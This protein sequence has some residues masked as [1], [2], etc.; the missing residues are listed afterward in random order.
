MLYNCRVC[1]SASND[2][3]AQYTVQVQYEYE[4]RRWWSC[5]AV[6]WWLAVSRGEWEAVCRHDEG[7]ATSRI[8][9]HTLL[10]ARKERVG[11]RQ[12]ECHHEWTTSNPIRRLQRVGLVRSRRDQ[13]TPTGSD[14]TAG[15]LLVGRRHPAASF[16]GRTLLTASTEFVVN[17]LTPTVVIWVH[18]VPDRVKPSFVI[19]DIRA[20]WRSGLSVRVPGC[21]KLQMM[22]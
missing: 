1:T 20:L 6:G 5:M 8:W 13:P 10:A 22:G 19:F 15:G 9:R 4:G 16:P 7:G 14:V 2:T 18:P 21:Q 12:V 11:R 17:P 3:T